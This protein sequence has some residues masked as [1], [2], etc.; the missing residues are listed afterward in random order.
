MLLP[1]FWNQLASSWKDISFKQNTGLQDKY[2]WEKFIKSG[3]L[4]DELKL[5]RQQMQVVQQQERCLLISGSPGGG[6][7][8]TLLGRMFK[9]MA[10]E[11]HSVRIL[12]TAFTP[13]LKEDALKR[14]Q[15]SPIYRDL[16]SRHALSFHTFHYTATRILKNAGIMDIEP[17][18]TRTAKLGKSDELQKRRVETFLEN[19]IKTNEYKM[20]PR[21]QQLYKTHFGGFLYEEFLWM[22][23]N[24]LIIEDLYIE[25][26][27]TG[28]DHNPRVTREQKKTIFSLFIAYQ[29]YHR[30]KYSES[31]DQEDYA[32]LLLNEIDRIPDEL[33]YDYVFVDEFQDLQP[34]QLK[35]LYKLAKRGI[36]LSGDTQQQIYRRSPVSFKELGI[37]VDSRRRL[38]INYRSTKQIMKLALSL[39]FTDADKEREENQIFVREGP[40]PEIRYYS[41]KNTLI[42]YLLREIRRL[43]SLNPDSTFAIIH[44]YDDNN[45]AIINCPIKASLAKEFEII[46]VESYGNKF[47]YKS[48]RKP[49]F[50]TDPYSVKGLEF[51][52][53]FVLHFD[54]SHY[55][56]EDKIANLDNRAGDDQFSKS[57]N[58]DLDNILNSERKV[59]YVAISRARYSVV[60]LYTGENDLKISP[61]V[62]DFKLKDYDNFGFTKTKYSR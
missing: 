34:M 60:L 3:Q 19:Y 49:I 28:R 26:E 55:P 29:R 20:L 22:K 38:K 2:H 7:S 51:D 37:T 40:K 52:H 13:T 42:S 58:E 43:R 14:C 45:W 17:I 15:Q 36:T 10:Q 57:Y 62:R 31:Y 5:S 1:Y 47:H 8:I 23:A 11:E 46:G 27:R 61:F 21:E 33:K 44:R 41:N 56:R 16:Q 59:L 25:S 6:K 54:K 50:F 4:F 53:V 30:Q 18:D 48:G 39:A 32:L 12:Y 9:V 35:C 24:G